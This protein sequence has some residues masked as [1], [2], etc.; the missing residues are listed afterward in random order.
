MK[1]IKIKK[2]HCVVN[3]LLS[4]RTGSKLLKTGNKKAMDHW[5]I[6]DDAENSEIISASRLN[7]DP[8]TAF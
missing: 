5:I 7:T 8:S 6:T 2:K 1:N 4:Q 3:D